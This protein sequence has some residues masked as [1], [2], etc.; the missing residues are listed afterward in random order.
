MTKCNCRYKQ[1]C[2]K[3]MAIKPKFKIEDYAN[4]TDGEKQYLLQDT[5]WF[6]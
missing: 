6:R 1:A 3:I 4:L 2:E 5:L